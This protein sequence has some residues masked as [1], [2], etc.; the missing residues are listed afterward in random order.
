MVWR[1]LYVTNPTANFTVV[2]QEGYQADHT[3]IDLDIIDQVQQQ[4][5]LADVRPAN[6]IL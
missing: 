2:L 6:T 5:K 4:Q 3:I 1:S